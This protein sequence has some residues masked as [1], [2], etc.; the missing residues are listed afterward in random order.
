RRSDSQPEPLWAAVIHLGELF[1]A[2]G[3][4]NLPAAGGVIQKGNAEYIVRGVGWLKGKEDIEATGV[5]E[6]NGTPIYVRTLATVQVGPQYRRGVFEKDG[7]E[8]TG[9]V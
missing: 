4:S 8:V 1:A 6:V 5:K 7:N 2:V 3:R 9:G